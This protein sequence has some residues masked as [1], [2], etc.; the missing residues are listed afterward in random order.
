MTEPIRVVILGAGVSGLYAGRVLA[1]AGVSVTV[2][3]KET[4]VGG[5]AGGREI[6]GNFY[7]LGVHHLHAFDEEIFEDIS[8]IM[9]ARLIAVEKSAKI[10]YGDGYRRYPLEFF[11]LLTG[12]PPW[13]LAH[14]VLGLGLQ[15]VKNRLNPR[16][17]AN[18]EEALIQLY[19]QPLYEHF[20]RG[21][22]HRYWGIPPSGLSAS[23]VRRKMPRLS[24]VDVLK[25]ALGRFGF[26]ERHDAA[27]ESALAE[28]TLYYSRTG[29]RELPMALADYIRSRGGEV[30]LGSPCA[31]VEIVDSRVA[32]VR[33]GESGKR[34]VACDYLISTTPLSSL[35][36]AL[37]PSAPDEVV[38]AARQLR[39]KALAVYGFLVAKPRVLDALYVYY[40]DRAFHRIAEPGNSGM[41]VVPDGHSLLLAEATCNVG[42]DLWM[43]S[44]AVARQ[45]IADMERE[46]LLSP[47]EVVNWHVV[48]SAHAYPVF[49]LG[50]EAHFDQVMG[51]LSGLENLWSTG[52]QGGF[53]YPNMHAAMR[54]GADAAEDLLETA[55]RSQT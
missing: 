42:D 19:G 27:V 44:E 11:D 25:R 1:E 18:A 50:F 2:V 15:F 52:R 35:V 41:L 32:A 13:T 4:T 39:S 21:F 17:P 36:E 24:A 48:R 40:R 26:G 8:Q 29:S 47:E 51:F 37:E 49:E 38:A 45:M 54:M 34:R 12:I 10:R 23:F 43:G 20:F 22:T 5:L 7:D 46:G 53:S 14:S 9:G 31:A 30:V 55:A 28:E 16:E 3:E 33:A 6:D